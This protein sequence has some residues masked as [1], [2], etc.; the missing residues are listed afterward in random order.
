MLKVVPLPGCGADSD[1]AAVGF[2]DPPDNG[3]SQ[4]GP[5]LFGRAE[6]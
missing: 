3:Q 5:L 1:F 2:D 6:Q 4:A